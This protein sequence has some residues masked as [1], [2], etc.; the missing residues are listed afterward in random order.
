V[1][2]PI[3]SEFTKCAA[4]EGKEP[5]PRSRIHAGGHPIGRSQPGAPWLEGCLCLCLKTFL[6]SDLTVTW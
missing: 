4:A 5:G 3:M 2:G 6:R 1:T